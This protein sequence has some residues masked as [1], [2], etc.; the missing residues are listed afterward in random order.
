M[1]VPSIYYRM[2][3]LYNP[4]FDLKQ[5]MSQGLANSSVM[6]LCADELYQ[7][8]P[9]CLY[10][11]R[12]AFRMGKIILLV[13][14]KGD[15]FTWASPEMKDKCDIV[16]KMFVDISAVA[17]LDWGQDDG[18]SIYITLYLTTYII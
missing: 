4:G 14:L 10:E 8:K 1:N 17:Q 12:E 11:M 15:V 5:S 7:T 9:N 2:Y 16:G 3:C 18:N 13:T 6:L